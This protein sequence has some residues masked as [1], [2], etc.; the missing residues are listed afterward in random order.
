MQLPSPHHP[1]DLPRQSMRPLPPRPSRE[2]SGVLPA[3]YG[4]LMLAEQMLM[5]IIA[6]KPG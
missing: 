5:P 1:Q 2:C 3:Q 4:P 6:D